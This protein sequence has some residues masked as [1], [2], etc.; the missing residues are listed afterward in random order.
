MHSNKRKN[1]DFELTFLGIGAQKAV[2]DISLPQEQKEVHF[3]DWHYRKGFEWYIR[4][5]GYHSQK[6]SSASAPHYGEITPCYVVLPEATIAE[7][8]KCFPNLKIIFVARDLVDRAWSAMIMEL[9]DQTMGLSAGEFANGVTG[10]DKNNNSNH[11]NKRTKLSAAQQRRFY[12]MDRLRNATH[13]SR[14][15]YAKHLSNWY[16]HFPSS[17]ILLIDYREIESNPRDVLLKVAMHIGVEEEQAKQFVTSLNDKEVGQRV[18]AATSSGSGASTVSSSTSS[19]Q[20]LTQR[21]MLKKQMERYLQP[22][23]RDFNDMLKTKGYDWRL[24]D[25]SLKKEIL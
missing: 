1:A 13:D 16:K 14:S 3:W 23:A 22:Y 7:L 19:H 24:D 15:N 4:Q 12:F 10:T 5:F 9:R 17:S 25:F 6:A 11:A 20:L 8:Y 2:Y 18:N 21:P